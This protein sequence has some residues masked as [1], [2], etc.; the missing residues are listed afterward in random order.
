MAIITVFSRE[1]TK[2]ADAEA[3]FGG[4]FREDAG[5]SLDAAY[6]SALSAT[7]ARHPGLLYGVTAASPSVI[8]PKENLAQLAGEVSIRGSGEVIFVTSPDRAARFPILNPESKA[9]VLAS[10]YVPA[11]RVIAVDPR[12]LVHGYDPVPDF[13]VS[14]E[15]AVHMSDAPLPIS[16]SGVA[17]PVRSLWQTD[18]MSLRT[19]LQIAFAARRSGAVAFADSVAW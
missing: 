10:A 1:L 13:D 6:F 16:S 2:Y 17:D 14:L 18:A 11:D 19:I 7:S 9:T 15:G 4:I 12:A 3:I 5:F 8:D